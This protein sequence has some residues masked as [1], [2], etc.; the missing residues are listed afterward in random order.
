ME[1]IDYVQDYYEKLKAIRI[2]QEQENTANPRY[3]ANQVLGG[4][5]PATPLFDIARKDAHDRMAMSP[6]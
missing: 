6:L 3:G 5:M 2:I 4:P 1:K